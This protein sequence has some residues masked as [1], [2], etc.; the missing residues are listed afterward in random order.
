[1]IFT[2]T[3]S[4][5]AL[6]TVAGLNSALI[7]LSIKALFN[8]ALSTNALLRYYGSNEVRQYGSISGRIIKVVRLK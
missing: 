4:M 6:S 8:K 1:M 5:Q 7:N 2:K 3:L